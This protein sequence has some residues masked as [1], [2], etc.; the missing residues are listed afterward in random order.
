MQYWK[1]AA[2]KTLQ[3]HMQTSDKQRS[4]DTWWTVSSVLEHST[5]SVS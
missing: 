3:L 1:S 5:G 2:V 4:L